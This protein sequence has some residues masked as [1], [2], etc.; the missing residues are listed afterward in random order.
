[1]VSVALLLLMPAL[2]LP[3]VSGISAPDQHGPAM[4]AATASSLVSTTRTRSSHRRSSGDEAS[5]TRTR[6]RAARPP[7]R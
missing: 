3:R 4:I 6:S 2:V 5:S 1:M 7:D